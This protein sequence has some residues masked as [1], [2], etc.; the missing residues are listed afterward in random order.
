MLYFHELSKD[1]RNLVH[2][3][4]GWVAFDRELLLIEAIIREAAEILLRK[5]ETCAGAEDHASCAE[6]ARGRDL[7]IRLRG[8]S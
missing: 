8:A 1:V 6:T 3:F 5:C 4:S 7:H 2:V